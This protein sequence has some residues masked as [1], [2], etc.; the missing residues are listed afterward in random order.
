MYKLTPP[1]SQPAAPMSHVPYTPRGTNHSEQ[2]IAGLLPSLKQLQQSVVATL[3]AAGAT[4]VESSITQPRVL[5]GTD[6]IAHGNDCLGDNQDT[7][8]IHTNAS[9]L[10]PSDAYVLLGT[11]CVANSKCTYTNIGLYAAPLTSTNYSVNDRHFGGSASYYAPS[12]P[13]DLAARLFAYVIARDCSAFGRYC[14]ALPTTAAPGK[15]FL[16]YRTYLEPATRTGPLLGELVMPTLL[17]FSIGG[18]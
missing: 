5:N 3:A 18:A 8:Y 10:G 16:V 15:W 17:R 4:L 1:R 2:E 7:N 13:T 12:L 14:I 6:C 9:E 11:N